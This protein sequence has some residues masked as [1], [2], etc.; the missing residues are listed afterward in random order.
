MRLR[1]LFSFGLVFVLPLSATAACSASSGG[2]AAPG[3][4]DAAADPG[5]EEPAPADDAGTAKDAA[6]ARDAAHR[7]DDDA[8]TTEPPVDSGPPGKRV[9]LSSNEYTADLR[10]AAGAATGVAGADALCNLLA[11][12]EGI[13][14]TWTA[15]ISDGATNAVDR[16]QGTGP[17]YR[18][19]GQLAFLNRANLQTGAKTAIVVD[20]K[21]RSWAQQYIHGAWT[22]TQQTGARSTHRCSDWTSSAHV[23]DGTV[24]DIT[25]GARW[26]ADSVDVCDYPHH[27]YCFEN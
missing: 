22:G 15:W 25:S 2:G 4:A 8:S 3:D 26:S 27:L 20:E 10:G 6:R 13:G 12:A 7:S 11:Q 24:G 16:I 1:D 18:M 14:G 21:G 23:Q 17:W 19:D 9:F 5:D